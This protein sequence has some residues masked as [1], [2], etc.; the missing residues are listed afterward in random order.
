VAAAL[1]LS[2]TRIAD[3]HDSLA[4][5][6]APHTW[7]PEEDWVAYHWVPFDERALMRALGLRGRELEAFLY[8]D[9]HTLADL[10]RRHGI[11]LDRLVAKLVP[12]ARSTTQ[13]GRIALLRDRAR[14]LLTQGHLAQHVFFH[15]FHNGGGSRVIADTLDISPTSFFAARDHGLTAVRIARMQRIPPTRLSRR[16]TEYFRDQGQRG[17]A[18]GVASRSETRRILE[19]RR[20]ALGC[21][22]RRPHPAR[23]PGNPYGKAR[24]QHGEHSSGWPRSP[25]EQSANEARV[26]QV[27]R[28]LQPSCWRP[29]PAWTWPA[30]QPSSATLARTRWR[31]AS[32]AGGGLCR[33]M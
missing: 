32:G 19:R 16:L 12:P 11:E 3:A 28:S 13:G 27:R 24:L 25:Q 22:M 31:G 2:A 29:P 9:H 1:A 20:A 30:S 5:P 4:P 18:L 14:R 15:V 23:D 7:L 21:W 8:D 26:E 10:A 6:D 17:I 33:L